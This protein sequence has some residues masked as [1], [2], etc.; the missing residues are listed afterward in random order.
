MW[1]KLL[2]KSGTT[3]YS[4]NCTISECQISI[5]S[6]ETFCQITHFGWQVEDALS[7]THLIKARIP[8]GSVLS[9]YSVVYR[10]EQLY[11]NI[12]KFLRKTVQYLKITLDRKLSFNAH[13]ETISYSAHVN[14]SP[15]ASYSTRTQAFS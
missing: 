7:S 9:P 2:K 1:H 8:Q 14:M 15:S 12:R 6:Y 5:I 4:M 10:T 11:L 13:V 3:V